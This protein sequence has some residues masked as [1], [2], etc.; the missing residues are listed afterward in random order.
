MSGT[1]AI[2]EMVDG[3][4]GVRP[5]W[6]A[7]NGGHRAYNTVQEL[8]LLEE[9]LPKVHPDAV[10]LFWFANDLE[11]PDLHELALK[12]ERSGPVVFD[13]NA[14]MEGSV[15]LKWRLRQLV[16]SSALV[17]KLHHLWADAHYRDLDASER[18]KAFEHLR[19]YLV[20]FRQ[21]AQREHF[22]PLVA[23]VPVNRSLAEPDPSETLYARCG[24]LAHA[25]QIATLDLLPDL[26]ALYGTTKHLPVLAYDGHYDP[27]ANAVMAKTV[28]RALAQ[29]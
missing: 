1:A 26:K 12:L 6:R 21:L 2:D 18:E 7:L 14:R 4:G 25:A 23:F 19:D 17:M 24:E 28:A 10:V 29:P 9:L 22:R 20:H 13:V 27:S 11:E 3:C 16:R 5:H 15:E 8:A